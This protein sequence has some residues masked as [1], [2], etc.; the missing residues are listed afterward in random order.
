MEQIAVGYM[1]ET[2]IIVGN[3]YRFDYPEH[4]TSLP[5]YTAHRGQQVT[6]IRACTSEEADGPEKEEPQMYIIRANDGWIGEAWE[7]ELIAKIY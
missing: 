2:P 4:F 6:V 5:E 1:P 7:D 3:S